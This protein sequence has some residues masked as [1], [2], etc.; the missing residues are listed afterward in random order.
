MDDSLICE[1]IRALCADKNA[2]I[3]AHYYTDYSV[4]QIADKVGDS[5]E[6]AKYALASDKDVIVFC[7]VSFMGESAKLLCPDKT[8]LMPRENVGCAMADTVSADDIR[9]LR[10]EHPDATFVCYVNSSAETKALCDICCT[11]ANAQKVVRSV[12]SD[13]V[14]FVPDKNLG[15]YVAEKVSDKEIIL[16]DGC[17]PYHNA[18]SMD[19]VA[20]ARK[21]HPDALLLTHPECP[22]EVRDAS[23][24][25]G[26]TSQIIK[27]AKESTARQFIIGT[28]NG[29]TDMLSH[30]QSEKQF[31][32]LSP[33]FICTDMKKITRED[34]KN[35]LLYDT[36]EVNVDAAVAEKA[37]IPLYK[38]T[39]L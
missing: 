4:L 25:V 33:S 16:F 11:S 26:S 17:C 35:A 27:F 2:L 14:V 13:K 5:L 31:Y 19:D 7:G 9:R 18:V 10:K 8:V 28:E 21:K 22:K 30:T 23:D 38:M 32:P 6:L 24:F 20:T 12:K 36:F 3:L 34:V 39:S 15:S 1:Q 29:V 37:R